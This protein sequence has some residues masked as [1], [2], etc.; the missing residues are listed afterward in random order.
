MNRV[1]LGLG[2]NVDDPVAQLNW[3]I[4]KLRQLPHTH[5][6]QSSQFR[7]TKP[8]GFSA[9]PDILNAVVELQT[10]LS[11]RE[12]LNATSLLENA[13]KRV[14]S[15]PNGPRTLDIDILLY[16][17]ECINEPDLII[18]HPRMWERE[19]VLTP[20]YEIAPHLKR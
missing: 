4:E 2:S 1:Y 20:L 17:E 19:F 9:Q 14:R 8:I 12:L 10:T 7:W 5:F 3:A 11:A 18:P 6:K 16:G 13:R 15:I